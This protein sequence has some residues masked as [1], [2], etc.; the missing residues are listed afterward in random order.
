MMISDKTKNIIK[1]VAPVLV[2]ILVLILL[3]VFPGF[4]RDSYRM[5]PLANR[6]LTLRD[7]ASLARRLSEK[8]QAIELAF[9][10]N[11]LIQ[12]LSE[13]KESKIEGVLTSVELDSQENITENLSFLLDDQFLWGKYLVLTEQEKEFEKWQEMI[14]TLY[15]FE[16]SWAVILNQNGQPTETTDITWAYDLKYAEVLLLSFNQNPSKQTLKEIKQIMEPLL[17]LFA[18]NKLPANVKIDVERIFF[19]ETSSEA[20]P[21][22]NEALFDPYKEEEFIALV[23]VNLHVLESFAL[24]D[25]NWQK[26]FEEWLTIFEEAIGGSVNDEESV[27]F[28]PIGISSDLEDYFATGNQAFSA[29]TWE[30]VKILY[31]VSDIIPN[32]TLSGFYKREIL[33]TNFLNKAYHNVSLQSLSENSDAASMALFSQLISQDGINNETIQINESIKNGLTVLQYNNRFV[34]LDGLYYEKTEDGKFLFTA[35]N[36]ISVLNS[37]LFE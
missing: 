12:F 25:E 3:F 8:D 34:D 5:E 16:D 21:T 11:F 13:G 35:K 9:K 17:P 19:P 22:A 10:E 7:E 20:K 14:T 23:D 30:N 33:Q 15:R 4:L 29:S 1:I 31:N 32:P 28:Y 36:Q 24:I 37:A 18:D 26:P 6:R 27:I 2:I